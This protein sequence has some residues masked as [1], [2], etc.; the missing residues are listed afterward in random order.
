MKVRCL[1]LELCTVELGRSVESELRPYLISS[2]S[3]SMKI[4]ACPRRLPP[5]RGDGGEQEREPSALHEKRTA[6][7]A[8]IE[9]ESRRMR[10]VKIVAARSIRR[11]HRH[12]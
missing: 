6:A 4:R 9:F 1:V 12:A 8:P 7:R 11:D 5:R 10:S 3:S 2:T